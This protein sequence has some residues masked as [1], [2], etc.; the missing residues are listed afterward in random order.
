MPVDGKFY[1]AAADLSFENKVCNKYF[2]ED[3][4]EVLHINKVKVIVLYS[5]QLEMR[6]KHII[7]L[8][9]FNKV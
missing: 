7:S 1:P 5:F 3:R 6:E 8:Y 2:Y 4:K 9:F